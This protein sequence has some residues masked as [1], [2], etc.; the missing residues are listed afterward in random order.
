[1]SQFDVGE[2]FAE[3]RMRGF[4]QLVMDGSL[5][6]EG[7][8]GR[9]EPELLAG[10]AVLVREDPDLFDVVERDADREVVGER[11]G[12][13]GGAVLVRETEVG[14]GHRNHVVR[15]GVTLVVELGADDVVAALVDASDREDFLVLRLLH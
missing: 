9:E 15:A 10:A 1:M 11:V 5:L 6:V 2:H 13:G 3:R 7:H 4:G 12:P 14:A 8:A